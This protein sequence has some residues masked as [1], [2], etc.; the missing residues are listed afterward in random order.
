MPCDQ[1]GLGPAELEERGTKGSAC[2]LQAFP[3]EF[4]AVLWKGNKHVSLTTS[5][6]MRTHST[7]VLSTPVTKQ[8]PCQV[9]RGRAEDT[10]MN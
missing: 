4:S 2:G 9:L 7:K 3:T 10:E 8:A 6:H 1:A 5:I